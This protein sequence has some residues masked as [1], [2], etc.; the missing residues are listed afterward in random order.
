M[1]T[2]TREHYSI[3]A[4]YLCFYTRLAPRTPQGSNN[5]R[6]QY[7]II[8]FTDTPQDITM[9]CTLLLQTMYYTQCLF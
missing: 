7:K 2:R 4:I 3:C 9:I 1:N 6:R 8:T 5:S